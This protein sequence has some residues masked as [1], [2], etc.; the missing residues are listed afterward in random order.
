[1][2]NSRDQWRRVVFFLGGAE[3]YKK[4]PILKLLLTSLINSGHRVVEYFF[5]SL[6]LLYRVL[7]KLQDAF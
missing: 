1:M 3:N 5:H 6:I 7:S 4:S 2:V